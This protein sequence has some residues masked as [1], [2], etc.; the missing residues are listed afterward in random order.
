MMKHSMNPNR[1]K[2]S[3]PEGQVLMLVYNAL[4]VRSV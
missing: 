2:I 4:E 3:S 1:K